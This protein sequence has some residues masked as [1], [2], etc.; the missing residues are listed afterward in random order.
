MDI[1]TNVGQKK[2]AFILRMFF[3]A[4]N[5]EIRLFWH[6]NNVCQKPP[7][8]SQNNVKIFS[9]CVMYTLSVKV[10]YINVRTATNGILLHTGQLQQHILEATG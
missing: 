8:P 2:T 1:K 4:G 3:V 10:N 6:V 9:V 7:P 5:E